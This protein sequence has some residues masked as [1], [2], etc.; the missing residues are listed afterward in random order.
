MQRGFGVARI[1]IDGAFERVRGTGEIAGAFLRHAEKNSRARLRWQ[2]LDGFLQ[3]RDA[4]AA[5]G[6]G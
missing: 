1:E 6:F 3:R 2:K 4:S 5:S